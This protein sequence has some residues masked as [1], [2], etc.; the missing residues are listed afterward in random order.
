MF[1]V[2]GKFSICTH[3]HK[4]QLTTFYDR[5]E[6]V[7]SCS[8]I[9]IYFK[10]FSNIASRQCVSLWKYA[11]RVINNHTSSYCKLK[12]P[13]RSLSREG[14]NIL[15]W[16]VWANLITLA[17]EV[18]VVWLWSSESDPMKELEYWKGSDSAWSFDDHAFKTERSIPWLSLLTFK[19][20]L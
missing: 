12:P 4:H 9:F 15:S 2:R 19:T 8:G 5:A 10:L 3:T 13:L 6:S 1:I 20:N 18:F 16:G 17:V 14:E 7:A 11:A